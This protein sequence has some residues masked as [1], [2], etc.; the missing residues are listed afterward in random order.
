MKL[1]RSEKM[2]CA[3]I[4]SG[5]NHSKRVSLEVFLELMC[6]LAISKKKLDATQIT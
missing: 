3:E 2:T 5:R 6:S 4:I 1:F